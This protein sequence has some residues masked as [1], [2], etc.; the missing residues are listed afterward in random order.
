VWRRVGVATSGTKKYTLT[1]G[2]IQIPGK[3]HKYLL[4]QQRIIP[5]CVYLLV[6]SRA[7]YFI[8][9]RSRDLTACEQSNTK[10]VFANIC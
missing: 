8:E 2:R 5:V 9:N 7:W 4:E 10:M 6:A 1:I 3:Q